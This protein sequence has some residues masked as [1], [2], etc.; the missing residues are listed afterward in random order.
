MDDNLEWLTQKTEDSKSNKG[1]LTFPT[2]TVNVINSDS[3]FGRSYRPLITGGGGLQL[4]A[5][6]WNIT[7]LFFFFLF[8]RTHPPYQKKSFPSL[9]LTLND[10]CSHHYR[11]QSV[12]QLTGFYMTGKLVKKKGF[13]KKGL[14]INIIHQTLNNE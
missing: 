13:G 2:H 5:Y 11:N 8:W 9:Q 4:W 14:T 7:Y 3:I 6:I 10:Q 12:D 1:N